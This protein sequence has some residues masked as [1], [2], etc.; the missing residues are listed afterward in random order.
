VNDRKACSEKVNEILKHYE[1]DLE[2]VKE[3]VQK[4]D[5]DVEKVKEVVK[6][7]EKDEPGASKKEE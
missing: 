7:Y 2:K 5:E 1:K 3:T 6:Q 4:H